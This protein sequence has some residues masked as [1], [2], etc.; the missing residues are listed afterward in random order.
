[1]WPYRE[2]L[3]SSY[4]PTYE[5]A[6]SPDIFAHRSTGWLAYTNAKSSA[7]IRRR[8]FSTRSDQSQLCPTRCLTNLSEPHIIAEAPITLSSSRLSRSRASD[9]DESYNASSKVAFSGIQS[10][11]C[12]PFSPPQPTQSPQASSSTVVLETPSTRPALRR[13]PRTLPCSVVQHESYLELLQT[14]E[15]LFYEL[16]SEIKRIVKTDWKRKD[17]TRKLPTTSELLQYTSVVELRKRLKGSDAALK[18]IEAIQPDLLHR[19]K[20]FNL[21]SADPRAAAE[22]PRLKRKVQSKLHGYK[23]ESED[24]EDGERPRKKFRAAS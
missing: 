24:E 2:V 13:T 12:T 11:V 7:F 8:P 23:E 18:A 17:P 5:A 6:I 10:R 14:R 21:P 16:E 22:V 15:I 4:D 20:M 9:E 1:L 3:A 19:T